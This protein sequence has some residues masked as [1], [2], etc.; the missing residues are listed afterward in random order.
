[1]DL[2]ANPACLEAMNRSRDTNRPVLTSKIAL[3]GVPGGQVGVR[4][5]TPIYRN[6]SVID[7]VDNRRK[8]LM[9]FTVAVLSL[10]GIDAESCSSIL[11]A[12]IDIYVFD[13]GVS[14]HRQPLI[15]HPSRLR[16]PEA[17][18]A[19]DDSRQGRGPDFSTTL[20]VAGRRWT[21]MCVAAPEFLAAETTWYPLGTGVAGLLLSGLLALYLVGIASRNAR[22]TRLAMQLADTNKLL[23]RENADRRQAES[24]LW[25]SEL[26]YKT[27]YDSS[28]DAIMLATID[29]GFL[30]GNPAAIALFRCKDEKAF[31]LCGPAD[32]SPE[33]QP[34]GAL[35]STKAQQMME[36]ALQEG[37]HFFEWMHKRTDGSEFCATVLLTRMEIEGN[38]YLLATVRDITEQKRV[39]ERQAQSLKR[40]EGVNRLQEDLLLPQSVEG[41]FKMI[42]EAAVE[43][44]DL[45]FCRVWMIKDA[46][47][48]QNGC[49]HAEAADDCHACRS[50]E[51]CLHLMAS[52]GRYTH[53]DGD[54]R[55]VPVGAYKIGRIASAEDNKFLTNHVTSDPRV[56]N[57][58]WAESLGLVSFA[59]YK[60]RD[61]NGKA[62]GVLAMF[63]KHAISEEDDAFLSNLA[64]TTSRVI[65]DDK[66]G[67]ALHASERRHRLFAENVS[68]VIW[69]LD[70]SGRFTYLS[71]SL[72]Q[73]L[74][75]RWEDGMQLT[76]ADIMTGSSLAIAQEAIRN[77]VVAAQAGQ[78]RKPRVELELI[79]KDG[80]TIWTDITAS[81]MYDETNRIAGIVGVAR[82]ITARKQMEDDLRTAKDAAEAATRAKSRFLANMSHEIR[83]PMTAILGYAELLMDP[84]IGASSRNNYLATIRRSGEH[85]LS[86]IND[87]LDLSKIEAGKMS[88][89]LQPCNVVAMLADVASMVRPRAEQRGVS[90]SVEYPAELP[91]TIQTDA[92]RLRQAIINL[93]G[94]AVKFTEQGSVRIVVSFLPQ[95]RDDEPAVCIRGDR[96]GHR[97]PRASSAAAVPTV[98]AGRCRDSRQIR[99][100][101]AGTGHFAPHRPSAG[102]GIDRRKPMGAGQHLHTHHPRGHPRKRPHAS[103]SG[104]GNAGDGPTRTGN[105][106]PRRS[107][108]CA[109]CWPRM[110]TTIGS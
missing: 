97:H 94:N 21:V 8:N 83:T 11:P 7:T 104:R 36:I 109:S 37:S 39:A 29:G 80:S 38:R 42:T 34:D 103:K 14:G 31:T 18:L 25:A 2:A 105:R 33:Y 4:L 46:D 28:S 22:T 13:G 76:V 89:D 88:L 59:G 91:E 54:H 19:P 61:T 64:E 101:R 56:H 55:R 99:R 77:I 10:K 52:A 75:L 63:A 62:I 9:G 43:L 106:P 35:S 70:F 40:L 85:L 72:E 69:A 86:L 96:H 47:L 87:I 92:A 5:F 44:L 58:Q 60:L 27:L 23:E 57:H 53:V 98:R 93:A 71:P 17:N 51:K 79:R 6:G 12:G 67:E 32:L 65:M 50:R 30:N 3:P 73:M 66:V 16:E 1:M 48:C 26:R 74:G 49:M 84:T 81:G 20:D 24:T 110:D 78:R 82:D 45:D 100:H 41:K 90:F 68:D 102:R 108:E 107:R 95:W 15:I